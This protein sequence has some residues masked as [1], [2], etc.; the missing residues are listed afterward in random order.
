MIA[1]DAPQIEL[2]GALDELESWLGMC[3]AVCSPACTKIRT[4]ILQIQKQLYQLQADITVKRHHEVTGMT[5]TKM[6]Q[7]ID[8]LQTLIPPIKAFILPG[9]D[10]TGASL[11]YARTLARRAERR[12]VTLIR[13]TGLSLPNGQRYLNRLSDYLFVLAR[14][15]NVLDNYQDIRSDN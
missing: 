7:R 8:Q 3:C 14:Y 5:V 10:Q 9:G 1:K 15:A 13:L 6:E 4:E 12:L 11:Q 2:L